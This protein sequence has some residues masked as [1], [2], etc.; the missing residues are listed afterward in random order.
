MQ[1]LEFGEADAQ[2]FDDRGWNLEST[3]TQRGAFLGELHVGGPFVGRA[4]RTGDEPQAASR[5]SMGDSVAESSCSARAMSLT[6][7]GSDTVG[8]F[9]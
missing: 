1:V 4:T 9:W 7:S 2:S 3:P 8:D 5:L 6:D